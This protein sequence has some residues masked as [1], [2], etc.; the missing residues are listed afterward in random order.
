[1]AR[2]GPC[3]HGRYPHLHQVD[4]DLSSGRLSLSDAVDIIMPLVQENYRLCKGTEFHGK[5]L[6]PG[7]AMMLREWVEKMAEDN[8]ESVQD[9]VLER[10][11]QDVMRIC[12]QDQR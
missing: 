11:Y 10:L 6:K 12:E 3:L 7:V 5:G 8:P 9:A 2:D 1:M 4:R